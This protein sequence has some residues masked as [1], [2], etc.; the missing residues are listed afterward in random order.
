MKV[1]LKPKEMETLIVSIKVFSLY[2]LV[3]ETT[4]SDQQYLITILDYTCHLKVNL[5]YEF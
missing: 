2:L 5:Y 3:I 4:L 1:R